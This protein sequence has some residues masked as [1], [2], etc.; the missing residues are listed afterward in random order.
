MKIVNQSKKIIISDKAKFA[1][2]VIDQITGLLDP[3]NPRFLIFDTRYGIHTFF[4]KTPID[5]L[6]LNEKH[7]VV[8]MKKGLLPN[9]LFLYSPKYKTVVEMPNG[10]IK[11]YQICIN[12]KISIK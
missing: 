2:S 5:V 11:K 12:D 8:K 7:G 9:K 3:S 1:S 6:I 4:M 10:S